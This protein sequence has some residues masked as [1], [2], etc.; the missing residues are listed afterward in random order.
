MKKKNVLFRLLVLAMTAAMV[1]GL[2]SC[3]GSPNYNTEPHTLNENTE[4]TEF[5]I[6]GA[7]SAL[8]PGYEDNEVLNALM[9]E[10]GIHITWNTMSDSLSEQVNIRIAGDIMPDA[11]MGVGF[12]NYALS[13][14]GEDGAFI[15][16]T[17]YITPEITVCPPASRWEPRAWARRRTIPFSPSPSSP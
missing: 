5:T 9:D 16:L 15:D 6:M 17:P 11:F 8:S 2:C 7:Q 14:H 1:L 3:S 10:T 12:N 13:M 4:Q